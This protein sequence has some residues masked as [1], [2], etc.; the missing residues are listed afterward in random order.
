MMNASNTDD[1]WH[2]SS[3]SGSSATT[4]SLRHIG[5]NPGRYGKRCRRRTMCC[6]GTSDSLYH[7]STLVQ[8]PSILVQNP[9]VLVQNPSISVQSP[10]TLVQIHNVH[11]SP[12]VVTTIS[13]LSRL[14]CF[15]RS[16][17]RAASAR[18]TYKRRFCIR[19]NRA[20]ISIK[21]HSKRTY[22]LVYLHLGKVPAGKPFAK[23]I[24]V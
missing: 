21:I 3:L 7:P 5:E 19:S 20:A 18:F 4:T 8:N 2:P 24:I 9:S 1:T 10:S 22:Q 17:T 14:S 16:F 11:L 23:I 6:C 13:S 15:S 12:S